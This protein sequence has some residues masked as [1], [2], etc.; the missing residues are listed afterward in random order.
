MIQPS[1]HAYGYVQDARWFSESDC[2]RRLSQTR[3]AYLPM[4]VNRN[5]HSA[6][7]RRFPAHRQSDSDFYRN[8]LF[9]LV[10]DNLLIRLFIFD[11]VFEC[12]CFIITLIMDI[13]ELISKVQLNPPIWDKRIKEHSNRNIVD[14]CWKKISLE[15]KID[16]SVLRKKWKYLRDQFSVECS[17]IKPARSGDA[18]D[19]TIEPKWPH[20]KGMLFL[21]DVIKP[22]ASSSNLKKTLSAIENREEDTQAE[23]NNE[24]DFQLPEDLD[25][26]DS[27]RGQENSTDNVGEVQPTEENEPAQPSASLQ[28]KRK[29]VLANSAYNEKILQLEQQK[30]DTIQN[31][32]QRQPENDDLMFLKSLLPFISKI[33]QEKKLRFRSRIQQVVDEFAFAENHSQQ[34]SPV[35][36]TSSRLSTALSTGSSYDSR[37]STVTSYDI[38]PPSVNNFSQMQP[39]PEGAYPP[40]QEGFSGGSSFAQSLN[41]YNSTFEQYN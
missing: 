27:G 26:N 5:G 30:L 23:E 40:N 15:M 21:K 24:F 10:S 1:S 34:G 25:I 17:E 39:S 16:G 37:P 8:E 36:F 32:F 6:P 20:F 22:R 18:A 7:A 2:R 38:R 12:K 29:R 3:R 33:P 31:A 9:I 41:V 19:T 35:T 4:L 28:K 11:L 14:A 13:D